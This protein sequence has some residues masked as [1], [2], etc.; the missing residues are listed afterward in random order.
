MKL[1]KCRGTSESMGKHGHQASA[2]PP[3]MRKVRKTMNTMITTVIAFIITSTT[4]TTNIIV[5]I[6]TIIT[7]YYYSLRPE[8]CKVGSRPDCKST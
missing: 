5:T 6:V 1:Q 7:I 8:A 3:V 4:I 2:K